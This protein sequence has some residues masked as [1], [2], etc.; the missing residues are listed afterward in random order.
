MAK[1]AGEGG[2]LKKVKVEASGFE[3]KWVAHLET[4]RESWEGIAVTE[5]NGFCLEMGVGQRW[6][7][8]SPF[9]Q[10]RHKR[11]GMFP[12]TAP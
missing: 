3:V 12:T 9:V 4:A 11:R 5:E 6:R 10:R 8:S 7:L 1:N 2:E